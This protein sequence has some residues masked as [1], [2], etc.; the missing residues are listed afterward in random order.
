MRNLTNFLLGLLLLSFGACQPTTPSPNV[1]HIEI[2]YDLED[3]LFSWA[4]NWHPGGIALLGCQPDFS[5]DFDWDAPLLKLRYC[6][7]SGNLL[8]E[9]IAIDNG[10]CTLVVP[11][12]SAPLP[13]HGFMTWEIP[14][15]ADFMQCLQEENDW[16]NLR[17]DFVYE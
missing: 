1:T 10:Y 12:L 8:A 7:A 13:D 2:A 4:D 15:T 6:T 17:F 9:T 3:N 16:I 14:L 5:V 11:N